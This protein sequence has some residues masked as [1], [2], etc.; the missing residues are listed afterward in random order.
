[1]KKIRIVVIGMGDRG[2]IHLHGILK[3]PALFEVVGIC[4]R[5]GD[6]LAQAADQYHIEPQKCFADAEEMMRVT[7]PDAMA[8]VTL[9]Q[10]REELV[11]LAVRYGV[12]G[13]MFE[14]PMATSLQEA[15]RITQR[16][17]EHR[18]KAVVCQQHKY[19]RSFEHLRRS[20]DSG[21]L[22]TVQEIR[23]SC[24]AQAS[25]L[26]THY[27]DYTLWAAG[28]TGVTSVA[29]H[30]HGNF[31]LDNSHPSP[32][33]LFGQAVLDNGVRAI[34]ECGYFSAR[35][36]EY[37]VTF[38]HGGQPDAYWT[39]DRLTVHGTQGYAYA[40]CNG[41]WGGCSSA[42]QGKLVCGDY[43]DFFKQEQYLAQ[44]KYTEAF[45]HWMMGVV[46]SHSCDVNV[47]YTGFQAIEAMYYSALHHT[48]VD[49]PL[50]E[51]Q[52]QFDSVRAMRTCLHP[53]PFKRFPRSE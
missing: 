2:K 5:N 35:H 29:A 23:V 17:N 20:I 24:Q 39:D 51:E 13:L 34:F 14:K 42:T 32:D 30:V 25:Q 7:A 41:R 50:S 3:N 45:G 1:M 11:E 8:F 4:D 9:P 26:G 48:R 10:V 6:T 49:F 31:Y 53:V 46:P 15:Q 22:G 19:L 28:T 33:Y 47:A 27:M 37:D 43:H 21:E 38:A 52:L 40:E 16:C 36:A 44:E 18:I 12:K